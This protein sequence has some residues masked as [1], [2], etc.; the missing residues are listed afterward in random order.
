MASQVDTVKTHKTSM[1][2]SLSLYLRNLMQLVPKER[3]L[4]FMSK[5]MQAQN[6][7]SAPSSVT[8]VDIQNPGFRLREGLPETLRQ[9]SLLW[10]GKGFSFLASSLATT[11]SNAPWSYQVVTD[12]PKYS[13]SC[14]PCHHMK[15]DTKTSGTD[16]LPSHTHSNTHRG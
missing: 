2:G 10:N 4:R 11:T 12:T 14:F 13:M 5:E 8:T 15:A 6:V 3:K 1:A 7:S 9:L 16:I